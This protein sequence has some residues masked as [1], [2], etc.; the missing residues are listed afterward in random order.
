MILRAIRA[1]MRL[2]T[3][4]ISG[5]KKEEPKTMHS[6]NDQ[7]FIA[8]RQTESAATANATATTPAGVQTG[9][10]DITYT[11]ETPGGTYD[12]SLFS[13]TNGTASFSGGHPQI[14][15]IT[16][17]AG[18]ALVSWNI[19][20]GFYTDPD[21]L[22]SAASAGQRAIAL[23]TTAPVLSGSLVDFSNSPS[24]FVLTI[25]ASEPVTG[26]TDESFNVTNGTGVITGSGTFYQLQIAPT[27]SP[28][29]VTLNAGEAVDA[30]GNGNAA[31]NFGSTVWDITAPT[32]SLTAPASANAPF[33]ATFTWTEP[34]IGFVI[35]DISVDN[36]ATLSN[37]TQIDPLNYSVLVS[38]ISDA[39]I[40]VGLSAGA[41]NDP[42]LNPSIAFTDIVVNYD[43]TPITFL[44][45][46]P[47]SFMGT[48]SVTL[49]LSSAPVTPLTAAQVVGTN[50]ATVT[51]FA[52]T[53][54]TTATFDLTGTGP[55]A[56]YQI[57]AGAV[58][59]AAGNDS[60]IHNSSAAWS[61][62]VPDIEIDRIEILGNGGGGPLARVY[63]KLN[64]GFAYDSPS[65]A[66]ITTDNGAGAA[67]WIN[68]AEPFFQF[69]LAT[70][71]DDVTVI[72][73]DTLTNPVASADSAPI[74]IA[75]DEVNGTTGSVLFT[76]LVVTHSRS[77]AVLDTYAND[78]GWSL[79]GTAL[80]NV[81]TP[82]PNQV[83]IDV[84]GNFGL[85]NLALNN[86][87]EAGDEV[88]IQASEIVRTGTGWH[89]QQSSTP[90]GLP[91]FSYLS[92]PSDG[93]PLP[94]DETRVVA[95][96]Q[97]LTDSFINIQ[98]AKNGSQQ[99]LW[100]PLFSAA[101]SAANTVSIASG[102]DGALFT[103]G[104][105]VRQGFSIDADIQSALTAG[106]PVNI[107]SVTPTNGIT[108][109]AAKKRLDVPIKT[110]STAGAASVAVVADAGGPPQTFT[111]PITV[112]NQTS[113][114]Q[115]LNN[116]SHHTPSKIVDQMKGSIGFTDREYWKHQD[117]NPS[118]TETVI[119][120]N[121]AAKFW[122][123]APAASG[124]WYNVISDGNDE[125]GISE[126]LVLILANGNAMEPA[127]GTFSMSGAT[128]TKRAGVSGV[129]DIDVS[130]MP[131]AV[132]HF[133][134]ENAS[135]QFGGANDNTRVYLVKASFAQAYINYRDAN[136]NNVYGWD[137]QYFDDFADA[138]GGITDPAWRAQH[139][140]YSDLR[141]YNSNAS[142]SSTEIYE[143][144]VP[145]TDHLNR[146]GDIKYGGDY[147]NYTRSGYG[148]F[149]TTVY[150]NIIP[151]NV[152]C[153]MASEVRADMGLQVALSSRD[154]SA[155]NQGKDVLTQIA[156]NLEQNTVWGQ[157]VGVTFSNEAWNNRI[158]YLWDMEHMADYRDVYGLTDF[159]QR[160][161]ETNLINEDAVYYN[162]GEGMLQIM[163]VFRSVFA[164]AGRECD[165]YGICEIFQFNHAGNIQKLHK[166]DT[167]L[168]TPAKEYWR[169][170]NDNLTYKYYSPSFYINP[171]NLFAS[172]DPNQNGSQN[173]W[174]ILNAVNTA[175][176]DFA[177]AQTAP[178]QAV[179]DNMVNDN[180]DNTVAP[181]LQDRFDDVRAIANSRIM[182]SAYEGGLHT[183]SSGYNP[184]N[185][186][187]NVP[188]ADDQ[189]LVAAALAFYYDSP[190]NEALLNK[191]LALYQADPLGATI[192]DFSH[193]VPDNDDT[194]NRPEF[195]RQ[196]FESWI[197]HCSGDLSRH[198][199]RFAV[200][201]T[202]NAAN[203]PVI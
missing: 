82:A 13:V 144:G 171:G 97:T 14:I 139:T 3:R 143:N 193:P 11:P 134:R 104:A 39:D 41:A 159:S 85:W 147:A 132:I 145:G 78:T 98:A 57:A 166:T 184:N 59:D 196:P 101:S 56:S 195:V 27:G 42:A 137:E 126:N 190:L 180:W 162:Y 165:V 81:T 58:Q 106:N 149:N 175:G 8:R 173:Y 91:T 77:G 174:A 140:R 136:P 153:R 182:T 46:L 200:T 63:P 114:G 28:V 10:F 172:A 83:M 176:G 50:G 112:L 155:H 124:F 142:Y 6:S 72:L 55:T 120:A 87:L 84:T 38:P 19:G 64:N 29:S 138:V 127:L 51:N 12:T 192:N 183:E 181:A 15:T 125:C 71:T 109:D 167:T 73:N 111:I 33:T 158:P 199:P 18:A 90:G 186:T 5:R 1:F 24:G 133:R 44:D 4:P 163:S 189:R 53:G 70:A 20:A 178:V 17:D 94:F 187:A 185:S 92:A 129:Y 22:L 103:Q 45:D 191:P 43:T 168:G 135:F 170:A 66:D 95:A 37:F 119:F 154:V 150:G 76:D 160:E 88:R 110:A 121:R 7:P 194:R 123:S 80:L 21:G 107:Q 36:G 40:T 61:P 89:G 197:G 130:T 152:L 65:A 102:A 177:A 146:A 128:I 52:I 96:T 164:A 74:V 169:D 99:T 157:K 188:T 179:I 60:L 9:P 54:P 79:G 2:L 113:M 32:G 49:N 34:V 151:I 75:M 141:A 108:W 23:D 16:P 35:T 203:A 25:N 69:P 116:A 68:G 131:S 47:L 86:A 62:G 93:T 122:P 48:Q 26:L 67:T 105:S 30:N 118:S 156:T 100:F 202:F 148:S 161:G 117:F 31:V 201:D 198:T 115:H